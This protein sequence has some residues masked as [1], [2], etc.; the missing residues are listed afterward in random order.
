MLNLLQVAMSNEIE[1]LGGEDAALDACDRM[2]G[3]M[4]ACGEPVKLSELE[5]SG[6]KCDIELEL[7]IQSFLAFTGHSKQYYGEYL[8][9]AMDSWE[10]TFIVDESTLVVYVCNYKGEGE[11]WALYSKELPKFAGKENS[12]HQVNGH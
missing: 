12:F 7:K 8:F 3:S 4:F 9:E 5:D 2:Y 10:D 1:R 6:D 11:G